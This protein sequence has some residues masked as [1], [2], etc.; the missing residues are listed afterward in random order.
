MKGKIHI[1]SLGKKYPIYR[2]PSHKII[3]LLSLRKVSKHAGHWAL[4]NIDLDVEPGTTLGIV[5]QNGSGK[6]TLL[7]IV[8]GIVSQTEG[9]CQVDGTVA[10]LL[11]LGA[12]FNPE[13][14]GRE[15]VYM[16][17]A[18]QG[19]TRSEIDSRLE[20]ILEFAEIGDFIDRPVKT[21]SSGMFLRLAFSAAIHVDPDVLLVDEALAVGDLIFQHRCVNRIRRMREAG[22]TILF[23]TH[24]LSALTRFCDR[25]VLIDKSR[26]ILD[27]SPEEVVHQYQELIYRRERRQ[28][29]QR[30]EYIEVGQDTTLPAVDTIPCIHNRYGEGGAQIKGILLHSPDGRVLNQV[31]AGEEALLLVSVDF[32]Q[33]IAD[34]IV[35]FTVRDH[36][37]V[38]ITSSNTAY[39]GVHLP[40]VEA[41]ST[42]TVGFRIRFPDVR[43][44]SYSI[45]PA[46][47]RGNI[48]EHTIEDWIDNAYIINILE[49]GL[50]YGM[51]RWP[52][53]VSY[54]F[55]GEK[56][57]MKANPL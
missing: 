40:A 15:N 50:I 27:S 41:G 24:D 11:E 31:N 52:V 37:G 21:Y 4:Q 33:D 10:A 29:G 19:M 16:N 54:R 46:V 13:F 42:L 53:Q 49:T 7:Q 1:R 30:D 5:G 56:S 47:A 55:H 2:K 34:A 22:K 20:S 6:S 14:S 32:K 38:E 26:K 12:G 51:M 36:L 44:G 45:S 25:A 43:P 23:V 8:A 48:W 3:E 18:I 9:I 57:R 28:A 35:G 17:A 39:E